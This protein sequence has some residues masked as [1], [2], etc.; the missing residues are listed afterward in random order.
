MTGKKYDIEKHL[1]VVKK[2]L[3][4]TLSQKE[5]K[6][7]KKPLILCKMVTKGLFGVLCL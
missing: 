7:E 4:N 1:Y 5:R 3:G 6:K 2:A